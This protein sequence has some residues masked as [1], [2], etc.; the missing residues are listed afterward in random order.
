MQDGLAPG[1]G[2]LVV[3]DESAEPLARAFGFL[4]LKHR[5]AGEVALALEMHTKAQPCLDRR[6]IGGDIG[7]PVEIPLLQAQRFN[8]AVTHIADAMRLPRLPEAVIDMAPRR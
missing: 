5:A 8:R 7:A 4:F 2:Q 3:T 1:D 6:V